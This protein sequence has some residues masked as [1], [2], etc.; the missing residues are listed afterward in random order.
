MIDSVF[1]QLSILLGITV[2]IACVMRFLR[3][4]LMVG[5]LISG[6]IA[7]PFVL[8]IF[9][10]HTELFDA[11]AELGVVLLLFVVGLSLNFDHIKRIGKVS[12]IAGVS[13]VL[14]TC[15]FGFLMLFFFLNMG[16]SSALYLAIAITFSS[17]IIIIK[18]LTDKKDTESVY[19]RYTIG[20]MIV[21]DLIALFIIV[22]LTSFSEGVT[23]MEFISA[24]LLKVIV[25]SAFVFFMG[26]YIIPRVMP[27]VA[28]SSEFLFLFTVAWCFGIA[29][30]LFWL[31]FSAEVGALIAGLTL[32]SSPYQAEI[33]S[34]V[35]PLRD[36]FIVLFFIILG[37]ELHLGNIGDS[38]IPGIVLSLFILIGNP[39]IFYWVFR[40]LKFTRRNSFLAGLTAAQVSEFGFVLLLTGKK[41]GH[42]QGTEMEIFTLVAL[43]T[44]II[45]SYLITYNE[46]IYHW[47]MPVFT[48][49]GKDKYRQKEEKEASYDVWLFGYHRLGWKIYEALQQKG[50]SVGVVDFNPTTIQ[51]LKDRNIPAYFGDAGDVE[52]LDQL[53]LHKAKMIISTMP[54][55]DDQ[56]TLIKHVKAKSEKPLCVATTYHLDYMHQLY[57]AGAHYVLMPHVIGGTWF[58]EQLEGSAWTKKTFALLKKQQKEE[59]QMR[60]HSGIA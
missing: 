3:Q 46:K 23:G 45:S 28:S 1:A 58:A 50:M 44:I 7:G 10:G 41:L 60:E 2:T 9:Q 14:F 39:L 36:F 47:L 16:F 18:L 40:R 35:K 52:F 8:N 26:R 57:G 43:G 59:L 24:L 31:G 42:I 22:L 4:P 11:L 12:L 5:Y 17:T 25:L 30:L 20:L 6:I 51:K 21:Q 37:S 54:D 56:V 49:F 55:V 13:Q 32:G 48:L 19:G 53:P 38:L 33:S 29:S 15:I 27:H 34:R